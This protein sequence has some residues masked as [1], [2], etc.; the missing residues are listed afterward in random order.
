MLM[1]FAW[2]LVAGLALL[3]GGAAP[4]HAQ[5]PPAFPPQTETM[6]QQILD[7]HLAKS[8]A[9][10]AL[11]GVW[12]PNRGTW[13]RAQGLAD[14]ETGAALEQADRVRIGSITKTFVATLILRLADA[15]LLSLD[16]SLESYV[17]GVLNGERITVRHLLAMT[18]GVAN[19]LE[20][21]DFLQA[22]ASD[23]LMPFSPRAALDI[24][25]PHTADF[26]PGEGFHYSETNYVLLGMIAERVTGMPVANALDQWIVQ[27][28]GLTS[29]SL[30]TT[31]SMPA[32]FS[33]GY[34]PVPPDGHA[35]VTLA[36][37][38][39]TWTAGA[40]VSN[41]HDLHVWTK[42]LATGALLSPEMQRER[43]EW[44]AVPGGEPLDA[45][46]GLG[47][48][49]LAGFLG[50]NGGIPGYSSI[51]VYLPE[52]D[53]TIIVLVNA[54]T[55]DGGPADFLFYEIGGLLFPERFESLQAR[56]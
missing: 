7:K 29:T 12:I 14:L 48:L 15:G 49:S 32:P 45:R 39:V 54:S 43:L 6:L 41:L 40:M 56:P 35:D 37:P 21:R 13:V 16:D 28:L 33:R 24:V 18:S 50:H 5:T 8:A 44:T 23:P 20:D 51:A 47:I 1:R 52:V 46:Y 4:A 22:Y 31:A 17:P 2:P 10:G 19:V 30:P 34:A 25:Q 27:P 11:V 38:D 9:P 3:A 36:N 42:A 26:E 55:L 53:A